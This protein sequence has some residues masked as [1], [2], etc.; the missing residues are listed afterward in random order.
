MDDDQTRTFVEVI[1]VVDTAL[2]LQRGEIDDIRRELADW[3]VRI[4]AAGSEQKRDDLMRKI[5]S[6][7]GEVMSGRLTEGIN[8]AQRRV[9]RVLTG[10][11]DGG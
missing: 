6:F 3:T 1:A 8:E 10:R 11:R 2:E 4:K 9:D 5:A 7:I